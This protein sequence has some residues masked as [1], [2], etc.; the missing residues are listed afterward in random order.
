MD[1]YQ[2]FEPIDLMD[3]KYATEGPGHIRIGDLIKSYINEDDFPDY[4]SADIVLIGVKEDRNAINNEGCAMA[5]DFV[6]RYLYHLFPGVFDPKI[7]DL[8]NIKSGFT[9]SDT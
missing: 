9:V 7:V 4:F 6:R 8:G 1:I 3:F 5:P 2:F